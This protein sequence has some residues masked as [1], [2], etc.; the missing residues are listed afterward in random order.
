MAVA[1]R[2]LFEDEK[3]RVRASDGTDAP[4]EIDLWAVPASDPTPPVMQ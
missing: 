1:T 2:V 4:L 3:D